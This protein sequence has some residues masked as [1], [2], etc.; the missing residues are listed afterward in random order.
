VANAEHVYRQA[1]AQNRRVVQVLL[2][3][4][5]L[6]TLA[7]GTI[8]FLITRSIVRP[9]E[10]LKDAAARITNREVVHAIDVTADDELGELARGM[11][12]MAHAIESHAA[13]Q[14]RSEAAVRELNASLERRVEERTAEL[15]HA[16]VEL[17]AAKELA[18][19]SN[20]AKSEFLANMSHE[21]RTPMNGIIGMTELV[22]DT[23]LSH[24][25]RESLE[26]VKTS[27]DYLLAVI[28]DILDFS[29]IEAGKLD[30]DPLDFTLRDHLDETVNALGL[31]AHSKGLELACHVMADVPDGLVGDPGRLRQ[32]IVNLLGNAIKFTTVGEVVMRVDK[33][34][35]TADHVT[36]HF[37]ITDTGI[38]IP[39]DKMDRLFRAFSQVDMST[40]RKYGG[41][42]LGLAI[43]AQLVHMMDGRI[44]VESEPGRGSTFHFT[45]RFGLS[46]EAI[47]RRPP[48]G[49]AQLKGLPVLVVDDH[50]TNCRI[51][52]DLLTS[53]GLRPTCVA[54]G[55]AALAAMQTAQAEGE[56][57]ALV[58]LD[59]M[60]PEMD[61]F[62]LAEQIRRRPDWRCVTLMMLPSAG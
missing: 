31:R 2:L 50:A 51:L 23:P 35:E 25:Q 30:L 46:R 33:Q 56:P 8:G 16:V 1:H 53:W 29:K 42:G 24:D 62:M 41:T 37:A 12:T 58:L 61:G 49:L 10:R 14:R 54:S 3:V 43:S 48:A 27:A 11:E 18:E 5:A 13:Q 28:N 9:I 59:N 21:I 38:G 47:P 39:A 19:G 26:M 34:A 17:R 60:M 15:E 20:R 45:A 55:P 52:Q 22:L 44:W 32:I 40:T 6:L 36:L 4:T 57:F 7:L